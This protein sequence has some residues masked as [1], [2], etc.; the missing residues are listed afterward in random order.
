LAVDAL[1]VCDRVIAGS[2]NSAVLALGRA[3]APRLCWVNMAPAVVAATGEGLSGYLRVRLA[4]DLA[5][6][7]AFGFTW[8]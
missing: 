6:A 2:V 3:D 7:K 4:A 8:H 1:K 5:G